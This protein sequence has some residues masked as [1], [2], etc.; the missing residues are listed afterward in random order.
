MNNKSINE[1]KFQLPN[2]ELEPRFIA[3]TTRKDINGDEFKVLYDPCFVPTWGK[4]IKK[5]SQYNG[6]LKFLA[7]GRPYFA[8]FTEQAQKWASKR[9]IC[10]AWSGIPYEHKGAPY[11]LPPNSNGKVLTAMTSTICGNPLCCNP[12]HRRWQSGVGYK[13]IPFGKQPWKKYSMKDLWART[14]WSKKDIDKKMAEWKEIVDKENQQYI[15]Q[16]QSTYPVFTDAKQQQLNHLLT[17]LKEERQQFNNRI[18][19]LENFIVQLG[20]DL[21][22]Q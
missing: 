3:S 6:I 4:Q 1:Y 9:I 20:F 22:A 7:E 8:P 10:Q 16:I 5:E 11:T 14:K 17:K 21:P 15:K 12:N 2:V 18:K 19:S 13:A